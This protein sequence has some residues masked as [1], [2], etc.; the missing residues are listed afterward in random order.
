MSFEDLVIIEIISASD[1]NSYI[2]F[3]RKEI[4]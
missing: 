4:F 2:P 3:L 1:Q